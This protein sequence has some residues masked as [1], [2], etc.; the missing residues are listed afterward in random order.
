MVVAEQPVAVLVKVKVTEPPDTPVTIPPLVTVATAGLLLVQVPP[1]FGSNVVVA[2][3]QMVLTPLTLTK[4]K[5]F[6]VTAVVV[7]LQLGDVFL[8][9]VKVTVPPFTPVTTPALVTVATVGSLLVQVPPLVGD[10][11]VVAPTHI[12]LNPVMLTE[13][14]AFTV[15]AAVEGDTQPVLELV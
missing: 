11:V 15:T 7:L 1:A 2:S 3:T 14:K 10:R 4:G 12:V 8:V 5:A 13:G 9:K 6:T